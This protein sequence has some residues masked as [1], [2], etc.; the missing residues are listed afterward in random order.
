M[1]LGERRQTQKSCTLDDLFSIDGQSSNAKDCLSGF[2]EQESEEEGWQTMW[3]V[4]G[5]ADCLAV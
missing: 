1:V 4:L 5:Q 3:R 2:W